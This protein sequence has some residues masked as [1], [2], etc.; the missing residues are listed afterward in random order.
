MCVMTAASLSLTSPRHWLPASRPFEPGVLV[1]Q[2]GPLT[3]DS[4][5]YVLRALTA[6]CDGLLAV[7]RMVSP[8]YAQKFAPLV[9]TSPGLGVQ[10]LSMHVASRSGQQQ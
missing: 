6:A 8:G 10:Q 9:Y 7:T 3:P 1:G 2:T 4:K 5:K